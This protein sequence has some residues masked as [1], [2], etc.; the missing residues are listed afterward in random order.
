MKISKVVL[1]S[2]LA[3]SL[4]GF[5]GQQGSVKA[6]G[7]SEANK[8]LIIINDQFNK[9]AFFDNGYVKFVEPIAMGKASTKTPYGSFK[10]SEKIVN[11]PYY[12]GHIAGG[13]SKNPL[14]VRWM[15]LN[16]PG[17]GYGVHGHAVGNEASI[18]KDVSGGCIRL[19]NST[20]NKVYPYVNVGTPVKIV[21][22][23]KSFQDIAKAYG[24]QVKGF[25]MASTT[26]AKKPQ[27]V[28]TFTIT[29]KYQGL[30]D[31]SSFE[32]KTSTGYEAIRISNASAA[33][34]KRGYKMNVSYKF[35][36]TKNSYG[37][38]ILK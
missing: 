9:L 6:A 22:S 14:G 4:I 18:G 30:I 28:S 8:D 24:Y 17:G 31:E 1:S 32:V 25:N 10:V 15:G 29:G 3:T 13:S 26:A 21:K 23:T 36:V 11:R 20:I 33:V 2:V 19:L 34:K 38:L 12:A 37:Q 16:V 5:A 27:A 7:I 35:L